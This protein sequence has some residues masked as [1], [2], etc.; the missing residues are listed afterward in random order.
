MEFSFLNPFS[1]KFLQAPLEKRRQQD[2]DSVSNSYGVGEG[3]YDWTNA[4]STYGTFDGT[5]SF[6][7]NSIMFDQLFQTKK[8]RVSYYRNMARYPTVAKYLQIVR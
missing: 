7:N 4:F 2:L 3:F 6:T 5:A 8:S 1:T